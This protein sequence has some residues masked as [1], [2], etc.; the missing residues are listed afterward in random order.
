MAQTESEDQI[1]A[2]SNS[3]ANARTETRNHQEFNNGASHSPLPHALTMTQI[4][5]SAVSVS[6][7]SNNRLQTRIPLTAENGNLKPKIDK[8]L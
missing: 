1:A 6:A 8:P 7:A 2:F 3:N 4:V 5:N